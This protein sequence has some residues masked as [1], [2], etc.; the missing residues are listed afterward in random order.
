MKIPSS[1]IAHEY[2]VY[3]NIE[4][5]A[6]Q[7]SVYQR[8]RTSFPSQFPTQEYRGGVN[9]E[10]DQSSNPEEL[11]KNSGSNRM[12][13]MAAL[14]MTELGGGKASSSSITPTTPKRKNVPRP[15]SSTPESAMGKKPDTNTFHSGAN[16]LAENIS[17]L[18]E[19]GQLSFENEA[20]WKG[21]KRPKVF[22]S[23]EHSIPRQLMLP[24]NVEMEVS[25]NSNHPKSSIRLQQPQK[26][27]AINSF[28]EG[29]S[30][31]DSSGPIRKRKI[32]SLD[33]NGVDLSSF[34]KIGKLPTPLSYR[35]ICSKCGKTRSEHGELGFG[36]KCV[37]QECGR[38]GAGI[39]VHKKNNKLM[40]F[41]CTLTIQEGALPGLSARY[42]KKISDLAVMATLKREVSD[43]K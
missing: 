2:G 12:E 30:V 27:N 14:A 7:K 1:I 28:D 9:K 39:Q 36:N 17:I 8:H 29:D 40:G 23:V 26:V 22:Q 20:K 25:Q 34:R 6:I 15:V 5:S 43:K 41:L 18:N 31:G 32:Q 13:I 11:L 38:C 19:E 10:K 42:D 37:F 33:R 35:K 3:G 4:E 21:V 16:A 24:Q